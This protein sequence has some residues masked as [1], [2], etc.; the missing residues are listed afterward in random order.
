MRYLG[1]S[2]LV[3]SSASTIAVPADSDDS[4]RDLVSIGS[5]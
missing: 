5:V 2:R 4:T 1:C 3:Y